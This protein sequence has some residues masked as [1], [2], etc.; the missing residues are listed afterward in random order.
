M[1]TS[2]AHSGATAATIMPAYMNA[3]AMVERLHRRLLDVV[4]DELGR[5]RRDDVNAAQALMLFNIGD[6]ELTVSELRSQGCYL[7]SNASYNVKKLVEGGYLRYAKSRVDRR[8]VRISLDTRGKE[9]HT[10]VARAYERQARVVETIGGIQED[11]FDMMS[12]S[13]GRLDRF[14]NDHIQYKM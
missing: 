6:R 2:I 14:W 7:G 11:D 8:C 1:S 12:K 10:I 3:I 13:M 9:I 4:N 5:A